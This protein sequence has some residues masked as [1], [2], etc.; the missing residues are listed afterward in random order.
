[1]CSTVESRLER[2]RFDPIRTR[3]IFGFF[4]PHRRSSTVLTTPHTFDLPID[5]N[6]MITDA[7]TSI[8]PTFPRCQREI[9]NMLH[10]FHNNDTDNDDAHWAVLVSG[11]PLVFLL[12]FVRFFFLKVLRRAECGSA[13]FR[14][15]RFPPFLFGS[16]RNTRHAARCF[17]FAVRLPGQRTSL[18]P[19]FA[20]C[21]P[22]F[23]LFSGRNCLRILSRLCSVRVESDFQGRPINRSD[24]SIGASI[25]RFVFT[26]RLGFSWLFQGR[27]C[28]FY[29]F[30]HW[31]WAACLPS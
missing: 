27:S 17:L 4:N 18:D 5:S 30:R 20:G 25:R 26:T 23:S 8:K 1:M 11:W 31:L 29:P 9:E 13:W 14:W 7:S 22:F 16:W 2:A 21:C 3:I 15:R 28:F 19:S 24:F 10:R 6:M 12:V